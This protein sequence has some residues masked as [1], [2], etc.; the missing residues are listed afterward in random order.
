MANASHRVALM[1][2]FAFGMWRKERWRF[3]RSLVIRNLWRALHSAPTDDSSHLQGMM[4]ASDFGIFPR[5]SSQGN[6]S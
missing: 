5:G 3:S 4:V 1:G 6:R 2:Q